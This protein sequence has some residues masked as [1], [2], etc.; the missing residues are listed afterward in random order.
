MYDEPR[1]SDGEWALVV[2]LL[3]RERNE[4]PVEIHH[5]DNANVRNELHHRAEMVREL[6]ARLRQP[7]AVGIQ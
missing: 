3:E 5:T 7:V 4:L 6:L 2:E 1:L